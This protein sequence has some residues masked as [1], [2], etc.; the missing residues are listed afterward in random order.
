MSLPDVSAPPGLKGYR[1]L[2]VNG[3]LVVLPPLLSWIG[4]VNWS[5]YVSPAAAVAIVSAANIGLRVITSTAIG[6][7]A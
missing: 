4:G 3:A 5:D 7:A 6:K 2:I 1:T